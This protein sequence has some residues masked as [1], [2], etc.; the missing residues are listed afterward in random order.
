[1]KKLLLHD[2]ASADAEM[3]LPEVSAGYIA[4][5]AT[6]TVH[7][8]I[9]C[10]GCWI[11]TP[12]RCVIEDRGADF[13]GLL[14]CCDEFIVVSRMVFGGFSPDI[15][16]VLDRSIGVIMPFFRY[17]NGEMHHTKRH[18]KTP[19][20]RYCFYG[21]DINESEKETARKLAAANCINFGFGRSGAEFY[22]TARECAEAFL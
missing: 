18:D 20:L 21:P 1:M 7:H 22:P 6:P 14:S 12:G 11:R 16:A 10:F 2:L 19:N 8:C 9:G 13:V 15:K 3:L 5:S 17:V 4:F